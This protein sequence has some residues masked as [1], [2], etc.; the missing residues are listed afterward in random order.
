MRKMKEKGVSHFIVQDCNELGLYDT[1]RTIFQHKDPDLWSVPR[2]LY[3]DLKRL[4]SRWDP[5]YKDG[6]EVRKLRMKPASSE[7][8]FLLGDGYCLRCYDD[9][10]GKCFGDPK[11][12]F[13]RAPGQST[14]P[15][16]IRRI[17]KNPYKKYK[18]IQK[19]R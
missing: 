12:V 7:V 10:R 14:M 2:Y 11:Y 9:K 8:E 6:V 13:L 3:T 18:M 16:E 19:K 1:T 15:A 17:K 4:L 5:Y